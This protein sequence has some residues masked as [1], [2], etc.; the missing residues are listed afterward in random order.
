M[1]PCRKV[2]IVAWRHR[3]D[4]QPWQRHHANG[5][6]RPRHAE[7]SGRRGHTTAF[8]LVINGFGSALPS[9]RSTLDFEDTQDGI[10]TSCDLI[11]D[12]TGAP[13]LFTGWE[14][15]D[16]YLRVSADDS[17]RL[18]AVA[19]EA[20]EMIGAFEKPIYVDYDSELCAHS[21]NSLNG[22]SRCLDVCPA[23]AITSIGDTV[24]MILLSAVAAAIAGC[25]PSAAQTALPAADGFSRQ[26]GWADRELS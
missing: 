11:I 9:S 14:K 23:G 2:A 19:A 15:R 16:G 5:G 22:C 13:P 3:D 24:E 18:A 17:V 1:E 10:E 21:R 8:D 12:L 6:Q 25:S 7:R 4:Q 26:M 20:G